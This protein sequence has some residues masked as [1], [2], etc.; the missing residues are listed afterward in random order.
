MTA[1]ANVSTTSAGCWIDG[2]WGRFGSA[3][4]LSIATSHGWVPEP[5]DD[6]VVGRL[7]A[8]LDGV[9][10]DEDDWESLSEQ[11]GLADQ[12]E[13]WLNAYAAPEGYL[14]GWHDGEFFLWP[15]HVWHA[16]DPGVCDCTREQRDLAW[17][18]L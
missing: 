13:V 17:R 18:F 9:E 2:H 14:F 12:A 3:R 11:G 10:A 5:A 15:E 6:E 8:E 7:I 4:L 1:L 16:D